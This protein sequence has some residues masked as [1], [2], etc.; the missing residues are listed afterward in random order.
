VRKLGP[1]E[2]FYR[3]GDRPWVLNGYGIGRSASVTQKNRNDPHGYDR[4][5]RGA[6]VEAG[7]PWREVEIT[8]AMLEAGADIIWRG[9]GDIISYGSD[10]GR[11]LAL[12]VFQAMSL[13]AQGET[14]AIAHNPE[15]FRR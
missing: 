12:K 2:F 15:G 14:I 10:F 4:L 11:E 13:A 1:A 9:F 5:A 8:P 6:A 3:L 7:A